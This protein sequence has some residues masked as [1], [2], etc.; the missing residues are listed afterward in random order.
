MKKLLPLLLLLSL[1]FTFSACG[2]DEEEPKKEEEK[3]FVWEGDWNDPNDPNFP[4][5]DDPNFKPGDYNP[6]KGTWLLLKTPTLKYRFTDDFK[7]IRI[8]KSKATG[9]WEE[10]IWSEKYIVNGI[11]YRYER[12]HPYTL[13]WKIIEENKKKYLLTTY[14]SEVDEWSKFE[15]VE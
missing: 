1:L 2:D 8:E 14:L 13:K 3:P 12:S 5:K 7:M 11:G 9:L 4:F 10:S 6:I 15:Y